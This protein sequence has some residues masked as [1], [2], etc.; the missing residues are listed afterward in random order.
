MIL[1]IPGQSNA[2]VREVSRGVEV[3]LGSHDNQFDR[4]LI[5][6]TSLHVVGDRG[7]FMGLILWPLYHT[8]CYG[9]ITGIAGTQQALHKYLEIKTQCFVVVTP[10]LTTSAWSMIYLKYHLKSV[11]KIKFISCFMFSFINFNFNYHEA[12]QKPI[13]IYHC[14]LPSMLL[15]AVNNCFECLFYFDLQQNY[16]QKLS[17]IVSE[18]KSVW[19]LA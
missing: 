19:L 15:V 5:R 18:E 10:L 1:Y 14:F 8:S 17:Y 4:F 3:F 7:G 6:Y 12:F 2:R 11:N 16:T 13:R 9:D